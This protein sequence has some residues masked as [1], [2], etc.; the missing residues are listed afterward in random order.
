MYIFCVRSSVPA[1]PNLRYLY[2]ALLHQI[3]SHF[4]IATSVNSQSY[5][6]FNPC[7][8]FVFGF[9]AR[10]RSMYVCINIYSAAERGEYR[11]NWPGVCKKL[12]LFFSAV[13]CND[14]KVKFRRGSVSISCPRA[15][16]CSRR[17]CIYC[18]HLYVNMSKRR[19]VASPRM[20]KSRTRAI[21]GK[22]FLERGSLGKG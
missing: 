1:G 8:N 5:E 14:I 19:V 22:T 9:N 10:F 17:P 16:P 12:K 4:M 11:G 13:C 7:I 18:I 15:C 3:P 6:S 21:D 2:I 20:L